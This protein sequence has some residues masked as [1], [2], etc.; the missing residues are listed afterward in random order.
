MFRRPTSG[1]QRNI[2]EEKCF[3][4]SI[5]ALW[6]AF[7]GHIFLSTLF[8]SPWWIDNCSIHNFPSRSFF[9]VVCNLFCYFNYFFVQLFDLQVVLCFPHKTQ[10]VCIEIVNSIPNGIAHTVYVSFAEFLAKP[11]TRTQIPFSHRN[12]IC[13]EIVVPDLVVRVQKLLRMFANYCR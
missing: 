6:R 2:K 8:F 5:D 13:R 9:V 12:R 10:R 11:H 1:N 4:M 7:H 3:P